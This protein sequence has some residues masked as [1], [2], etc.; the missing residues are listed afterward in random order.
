MIPHFYELFYPLLNYL[1]DGKVRSLADCTTALSDLLS[2]TEPERRALLP[3]KT[4]P[5]IR[6]RTGWAKWYLGKAG[7]VE[8]VRRGYYRITEEGVK[9]WQSQEKNL[10]LDYLAEHY[11]TFK[12]FY[13]KKKKTGITTPFVTPMQDTPDEIIERILEQINEELAVEVLEKVIEQEFYFFEHIVVDLMEKMGYGVGVR[14]QQSGD[15]GIDGVISQDALGL[16]LVYLQAKKWKKESKVGRRELQSFVGSIVG[17]AG[18]KGVFVTT[19][20]F[21]KEALEFQPPISLIKID[22]R[23]LAKY[24]IKYN[25]GVS[26]KKVYEIKNLDSDYFDI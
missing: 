10:T 4:M 16:D 1:S 11:P 23:Q 20:S 24:M 6:N 8:T 13:S 19:S 14:T 12:N 18:S 3:S 5:I 2:L 9:L 21:T 25:V 22:G 26:V 17:K 7:L 15:E